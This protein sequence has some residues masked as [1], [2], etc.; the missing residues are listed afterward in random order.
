MLYGLAVAEQFFGVFD[1][2]TLLANAVQSRGA[3]VWFASFRLGESFQESTTTGSEPSSKPFTKPQDT[4]TPDSV[5]APAAV[6]PISVVVAE[7]ASA[8]INGPGTQS[9]TF[10]GT[11][12]TLTI[13][14]SIFFS[15]QISGLAGAD[16][17]DLADI[18]YGAA[19]TATFLGNTTGG[20]LTVT[21]GTRTA[22]IALQGDYLSSGWTLSSD[23]YGGTTVVDPVSANNWQELK[24]GAGGWL[25]GIDIAPDDTMVVRTDTYGAYIWNGTQWQQ[26]VTSTSMPAAD[27]TL[28]TA[29]GVYEIQIAPSN[30]NILYMMYDGY[31][32]R[33]SDK[34]T[35]WT[36]TNFAQVTEDP[37]DGYRMDGQKMAVDPNN[38]NVVYVGT[39]QNGLFVTVDGGVTWQSVAAV[40]VS[41]TDTNDQ[42]PGITGIVFDPTSGVT[43]GKTNTIYASSFGNGV[44]ESTNGG[45]SWTALSGGPSDVEYATVSTSGVYYA[46]GNKN[47]SV[48]RFTNGTWDSAN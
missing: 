30:T 28:G 38:P 22:E 33:S 7:G 32:Y 42:Y 17:L 41:A 40:P 15:G 20:I 19:T 2:N 1:H 36:K 16:A 18:T 45:L 6:Q 13:D 37:N 24:I 26:L 8:E 4:A 34:G 29:Q 12:G 31:V 43:N 44:F 27:A 11:S 35:T 25:T 5:E 39:P 3:D 10:A 48:W 21:D 9:V 14:N 47:S 46:V 23:G